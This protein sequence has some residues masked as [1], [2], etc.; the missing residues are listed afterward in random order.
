MP[1]WAEKRSPGFI[2]G[3]FSSQARIVSAWLRL[4]PVRLFP[5]SPGRRQSREPWSQ[6]V[7]ALLPA[8]PE[9]TYHGQQPLQGEAYVASFPFVEIRNF[10]EPCQNWKILATPPA[11]ADV[12]EVAENTKYKI[13]LGI[14]LF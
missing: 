11:V 10:A 5:I 3:A 14:L 6:V 1:L 9:E 13:H 4:L 2:A 7:A 8:T 12:A